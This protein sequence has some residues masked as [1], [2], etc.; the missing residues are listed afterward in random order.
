MELGVVIGRGGANIRQEHAK[1]HVAG[2]CLAL[3]LTARNLQV[4]IDQPIHFPINT[5]SLHLLIE[6]G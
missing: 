6:G 3:D 4:S 1:R 5:Y 2:Y